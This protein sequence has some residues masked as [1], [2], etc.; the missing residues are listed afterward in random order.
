MILVCPAKGIRSLR[1]ESMQFFTEK[2]IDI[3]KG[4]EQQQQKHL[5]EFELANAKS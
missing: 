3:G 2:L 5:F 1:K 4:L